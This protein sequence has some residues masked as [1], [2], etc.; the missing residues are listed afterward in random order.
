MAKAVLKLEIDAIHRVIQR[1]AQMLQIVIIVLR[2]NQGLR[3][4]EDELSAYKISKHGLSGPGES[5][6]PCVLL[7]VAR[8]F[9]L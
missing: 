3:V 5:E 1:I 9:R 4:L 2:T 8:T 6:R 7:S